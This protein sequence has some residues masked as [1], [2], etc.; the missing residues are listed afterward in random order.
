MM[1]RF[2]RGQ[3]QHELHQA[4]SMREVEVTHILEAVAV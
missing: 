3:Q 2:G 4:Y 1:M